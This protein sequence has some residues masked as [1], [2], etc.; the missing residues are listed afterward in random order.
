[1]LN[2]NHKAKFYEQVNELV[3]IALLKERKKQV[4]RNYCQ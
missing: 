3:D 2:F 4:P 1:M